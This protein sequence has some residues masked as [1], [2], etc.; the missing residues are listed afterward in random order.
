MD[1]LLFQRYQQNSTSPNH[2]DTSP[3]FYRQNDEDTSPNSYIQNQNISMSGT[4]LAQGGTYSP[5]ND[6]VLVSLSSDELYPTEDSLM[7]STT[8]IL[9]EITTSDDPGSFSP[10]NLWE[11]KTL[12]GAHMFATIKLMEQTKTVIGVLSL[13]VSILGTMGN[14]LSIIVMSRKSFKAM[15]ISKVIRFLGICDLIYLIV[16]LNNDNWFIKLINVDI[17]SFS[18]LSC[19]IFNC[20]SKTS[21]L[22][23]ILMLVVI[24]VYRFITTMVS[25]PSPC[26]VFTTKKVY[27]MI[28][29]ITISI[30]S[31]NIVLSHHSDRLVQGVCT[32]Y[33]KK[34]KITAILV[35]ILVGLIN[36]TSPLVLIILNAAIAIKLYLRKRNN[37][38][39][40]S[41]I[42]TSEVSAML[43]AVIIAY[44]ILASPL[45]ACHGIAF[46][47][48]ESLFTTQ[49]VHLF[50]AGEVSRLLFKTNCAVNFYIYVSLCRTFRNEIKQ[51]F[52]SKM[53]SALVHP[54][55]LQPQEERQSIDNSNNARLEIV[56]NRS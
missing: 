48:G 38:A 50:I 42:Q 39:I 31:Y 11:N 10:L 21:G 41:Q 46:R 52:H 9:E 15:P 27:I 35:A 54:M 8:G 18:N 26:L 44:L 22:V 53:H 17:R 32:M 13:I 24:T 37:N 25:N 5:T 34:D 7:L 36:I 55:A 3:H 43:G 14:I 12:T 20:T 2:K 23:A 6:F 47:M 1:K 33:A 49:N 30:G 51:M 16:S 45:V 19:K 56:V 28:A 4:S 40:T 29:I